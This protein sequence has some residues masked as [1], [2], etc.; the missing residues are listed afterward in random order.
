MF[1]INS[2][3]CINASIRSGENSDSEEHERKENLGFQDSMEK[4]FSELNLQEVSL[5]HP[6]KMVDTLITNSENEISSSSGNE[7]II[8][9][10]NNQKSANTQNFSDSDQYIF[11]RLRFVDIGLYI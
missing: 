5:A 6:P 10:P 2:K 4:Y 1:Q 3:W 9:N 8:S 7:M 11:N